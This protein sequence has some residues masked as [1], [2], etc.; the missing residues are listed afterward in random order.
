MSLDG[1]CSKIRKVGR[2]RPTVSNETILAT[3]K[4]FSLTKVAAVQSITDIVLLDFNWCCSPECLFYPTLPFI[5]AKKFIL[6]DV[7]ISENTIFEYLYVSFWLRKVPSIT[8]LRNWKLVGDRGR[9]IQ[10][11]YSCLQGEVVARLM[12]TYALTLSLFM[13]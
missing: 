2:C 11:V 6:S 12:C 3:R 5:F 8:Y 4:D 10:N 9:V 13:F 7:Y 1:Y